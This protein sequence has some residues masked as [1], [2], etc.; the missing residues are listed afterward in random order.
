VRVETATAAKRGRSP[1]GGDASPVSSGA[2]GLVVRTR[3][4]EA[5]A[6]GGVS[7]TSALAEAADRRGSRRRRIWLAAG[8]LALV[9]PWLLIVMPESV[10]T[11]FYFNA[12]VLALIAFA[13]GI[14]YRRPDPGWPWWSLGAGLVV[15][16]VG[17]MV[18]YVPPDVPPPPFTVANVSVCLH[19]VSLVLV[20]AGLVGIVKLGG[21]GRTQR[22]VG[23]VAITYCGGTL[24]WLL[25]VAPYLRSLSGSER[26][27]AA[28]II[29]C[30]FAVLTMAIMLMLVAIRHV[31]HAL[32]GV[33]MFVFLA[34][35]IVWGLSG[36]GPTNGAFNG[37]TVAAMATGY[38]LLAV[39]ACHP[40][41]ARRRLLAKEDEP[42]GRVPAVIFNAVTFVYPTFIT[43]AAL[44]K[45]PIDP[46]IDIAFP[47]LAAAA[48]SAFI[49]LRSAGLARESHRQ[50]QEQASQAAALGTALGEQQTLQRQLAHRALHDP[51]TGLANRSKLTEALDRTL[52]DAAAPATAEQPFALLLL[53]LDGFK[54]VNDTHGHPVGDELLVAVAGRFAAAVPADTLLVRL[55]GDEF[56]VLLASTD[57]GHAFAVGQRLADALKQPFLLAAHELY[58]T[59]SVGVFLGMG[60]TTASDVLRNADLALYAAKGAGKNQVVPFRPEL[61]VAHLEHVELLSGLRRAVARGEFKLEYQPVVDLVTERVTSVE[62]LLRWYSP[63]H[64]LVSPV[65]FI[66]IA[67]ESGL[68]V[69]IGAWVLGQACADA[70]EWHDRF[71]VS[72][73]VNVAAR[74]LRDPDFLTTVFGALRYSGLPPEALVVEI[75]ESSMI[76]ATKAETDEVVERLETLRSRGIRIAIDDFGTGY[77]SLS[78]LSRLPVDILKIDQSFSREGPDGADGADG[79]LTKAILQLSHS[80][81]LSTVA[82]GVETAERADVLRDLHCDRAQGFLYSRPVTAS[83]LDDLLAGVVTADVH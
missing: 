16:F 15:R 40:S 82:E 36:G 76:A 26:A 19:L 50:A 4:G 74:Q 58:V 2:D 32:V 46:L 73:A 79:A 77:S 72:V 51:L 54:D 62:A 52:A 78:Y 7:P 27:Q 35:D 64:G 61:R 1:T 22:V 29:L 43:V 59:T 55:G 38:V 14:G 33:A 47:I 83:A 31:A 56:A 42:S 5:T 8:G 71:G 60:P 25:V 23:A 3:S 68:I 18:L 6:I 28:A 69:P 30:D 49:G 75:T 80:L 20:V 10:G 45:V 70:K 63:D 53:D 9:A 13:I 34:G 39:A 41:V 48:Y 12:R 11:V 67:E 21:P 66:P 57:E 24:L 65:D 17:R 44:T 81:G 37:F